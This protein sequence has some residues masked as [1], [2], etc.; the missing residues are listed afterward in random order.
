MEHELHKKL[1]QEKLDEVNE[2]FELKNSERE[3]LESKH[4]IALENLSSPVQEGKAN[5]YD[6]ESKK[7]HSRI[8]PQTLSHKT[9]STEEK[10][11]DN[12]LPGTISM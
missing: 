11:D 12:Q 7:D 5:L 4:L 8:P 6:T 2:R 9:Q 1:L 10:P 3:A